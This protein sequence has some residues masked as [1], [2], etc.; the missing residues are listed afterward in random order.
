MSKTQNYQ[1]YEDNIDKL[2][3]IQNKIRDFLNNKKNNPHKQIDYYYKTYLQNLGV[4]KFNKNTQFYYALEYLYLNLKKEIYIED[5]KKYVESK[6]I[7]LNGSDS[8]QVRHLA[9]QYG[10]NILKGGDNFNDKKIKKSHFMLVN[11]TKPFKSFIKDKRKGKLND[12]NWNKIKQ[13]YDNMCANCGSAEGKPLRHN[14]NKTTELTQGHM[15]PRVELSV[16]NVIP[17]CSICN[18]QYKN[19]AIFNKRGFVI[20]FNEN[21]F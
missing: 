13:E 18:Q 5:L 2:I 16:D 14:K 8:L 6:G 3:I 7:K 1:I 19:K 4:K 10:Y 12:E 11:L 20:R 9:Q 15:D 21:G 17:Q